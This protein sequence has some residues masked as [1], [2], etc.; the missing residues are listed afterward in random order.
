MRANNSKNL[1]L[2]FPMASTLHT[3]LAGL[4]F[5]PE[6]WSRTTNPLLRQGCYTRQRERQWKLN[7]RSSVISIDL[8]SPIW[9][10]DAGEEVC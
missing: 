6:L 9:S 1:Y 3:F 7:A 10:R 2:S 4:F 8:Y 5:T